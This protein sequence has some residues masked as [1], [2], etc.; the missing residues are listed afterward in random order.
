MEAELEL[1]VYAV[2]IEDG[3]V[4]EVVLDADALEYVVDEVV[5]IIE[6]VVFT[7]FVSLVQV[8][9]L[10]SYCPISVSRLNT[11]LGE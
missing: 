3:S 4:A 11:I 5:C 1:E 6:I 8:I 10:L 7:F 2:C 9:Y